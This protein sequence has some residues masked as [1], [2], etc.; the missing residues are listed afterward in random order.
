M[1]HNNICFLEKDSNNKI[2]LHTRTVS[3]KNLVMRHSRDKPLSRILNI[4]GKYYATNNK[5]RK[6]INMSF[7]YDDKVIWYWNP[8][9]NRL[10][11]N[12]YVKQ[13]QP[14]KDYQLESFARQSESLKTS[15]TGRTI[16][17][18]SF[19]AIRVTKEGEKNDMLVFENERKLIFR[20]DEILDF[21]IL[22]ENKV[23]RV[24]FKDSLCEKMVCH[25]EDTFD[26]R[27]CLYIAIAKHLYKGTYT[28]EGIEWKAKE[29]SYQKR[30]I[31]M[32][33]KAITHYKTDMANAEK[34]RKA[35]EDKKR[36]IAN[37]KRKHAEYLKRREQKRLDAQAKAICE[38]L[39]LYDNADKNQ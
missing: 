32:V 8:D 25:E 35:E 16:Q 31:K 1:R 29:I 4:R 28:F 26:L 39:K 12:I 38:G 20:S 33:D 2:I 34:M 19:A 11:I 5:K 22:K 37:K 27:Q 36:A 13:E 30:Y 15:L 3:M 9:N 7:I 10:G 14:F 17:D 6:V 18:I 23:V 24:L 21:D